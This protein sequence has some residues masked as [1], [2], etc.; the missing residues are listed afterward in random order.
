MSVTNRF[1]W[2]GWVAQIV[3][4]VFAAI[5]G[6][7]TAHAGIPAGWLSGAMF[8]TA[9]LASTGIAVPFTNMVR[10]IAL[11]GSGLTIGSAVTPDMLRGFATW[12]VTLT[13]MTLAVAAATASGTRLLGRLDGWSRPTAFF[14]SVPGALSYVFAVAGETERADLPRI[15]VVQVMRVFFLMGLVPIV[16]AETGAPL[17]PMNVGP[18]DPLPI[19]LALVVAGGAVGLLLDHFRVTAGMMFGAM[20]VAAVARVS[21]FAPGRPP[22][23]FTEAAQILI[24]AWVGARFIGFD[25]GLLRRSLAASLGSFVVAMA[26]SFACSGIAVVLVGVPFAQALVAFAPGGLEA[27]SLLSIALGLDPLFVSAHHLARFILIAVT[28]PFVLRFWVLR[29]ETSTKVA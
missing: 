8:A 23:A 10:R 21:G 29:G 18:I 6:F 27:M 15:A 28:L 25:W 19:L 16:V 11:L 24:G 7:A 3:T 13:I 1:G 26:I 5:G 17:I 2:P 4:I 14:A 20:V 9:V 22:P 12:P